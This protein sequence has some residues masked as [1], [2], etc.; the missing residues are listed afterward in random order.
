MK[1]Y[2]KSNWR[3]T[4]QEKI[5]PR[6]TQKIF[7]S[8]NVMVVNYIYEPGLEFQKHSHPQEQVTIVQSGS[9][10]IEIDGEKINLIKGDIC[11]IPPNVEHATTVIGIERVESISIFTPIA[12]RVIIEK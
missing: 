3:E 8:Q 9:L 1:R 10:Q 5:D 12:D 7:T 11:S 2:R 4:R 6:L